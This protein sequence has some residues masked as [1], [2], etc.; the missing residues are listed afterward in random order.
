MTN[1]ITWTVTAHDVYKPATSA[2]VKHTLELI[3]KIRNAIDAQRSELEDLEMNFREINAYHN[4]IDFDGE[5]VQAAA[6]R[7]L[8]TSRQF[9]KVL[10]ILKRNSYHERQE[11]GI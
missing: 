11:R 9:L 6:S 7:W 1:T 5:V 2:D 3:E 4:E 8:I 10:K